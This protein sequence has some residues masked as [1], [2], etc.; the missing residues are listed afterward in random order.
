MHTKR[1]ERTKSVIL[2]IEPLVTNAVAHGIA[3]P[4]SALERKELPL[5]IYAILGGF[6]RFHTL[7]PFNEQSTVLH[8]VLYDRVIDV[9]LQLCEEKRKSATLYVPEDELGLLIEFTSDCFT[10]T[11]FGFFDPL[12]SVVKVNRLLDDGVELVGTQGHE[13]HT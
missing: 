8:S 13:I 7:D 4:D 6:K 5:F 9:H 10:R 3:G 1:R 11:A 12:T 2:G